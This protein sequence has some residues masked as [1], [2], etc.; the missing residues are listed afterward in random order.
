MYSLFSL[1][2]LA[3]LLFREP[4]TGRGG[5]SARLGQNIR[6]KLSGIH[7]DGGGSLL[8]RGGLPRAEGVQELSTTSLA[9]VSRDTACA[10]QIIWKSALH[11]IGW[12]LRLLIKSDTDKNVRETLA[13]FDRVF[14]ETVKDPEEVFSRHVGCQLCRNQTCSF[15]PARSLRGKTVNWGY[16]IIA[17][18]FAAAANCLGVVQG[19]GAAG[20]VQWRPGG[21]GQL[22]ARAGLEAGAL[23]SLV[24]PRLGGQLHLVTHPH[25]RKDRF[26]PSSHHQRHHNS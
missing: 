22:P 15:K 9:P 3:A 24:L 18:N 7:R 4:A 25:I 26:L 1:F 17:M 19:G 23:Q 2:S 16:T 14:N 10:Q 13:F 11:V 6:V 21:A 12:H 8:R 20:G 5:G